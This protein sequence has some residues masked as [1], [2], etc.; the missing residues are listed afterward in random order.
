MEQCLQ[1]NEEK[2]VLVYNSIFTQSVNQKQ[3][4]SKDIWGNERTQ[5][6][7]FPCILSW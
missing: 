3:K 4:E 2:S 6:M 7:Y 5:K 1:I